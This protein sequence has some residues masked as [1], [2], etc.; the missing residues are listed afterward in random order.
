MARAYLQRQGQEREPEPV[1]ARPDGPHRYRYPQKQ[2]HQY[3]HHPVPPPTT[4]TAPSTS[5]LPG[6]SSTKEGGGRSGG[7]SRWSSNERG[8]GG[9]GRSG[10]ETPGDLLEG[11]VV[12]DLQKGG[13]GSL[14]GD[15]GL[16]VVVGA[17]EA[18]QDIEHQDPIG[19]RT[20]EVV[21]SIGHALHPPAELTNREV[22][23]LEGAEGGVELEGAKL[24][25]AEEL[26]LEC[27]PGLPRSAA[28]CPDEVLKI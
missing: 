2:D 3:H 5:G 18:P 26:P 7:G 21:K 4:S 6:G 8:G 10:R 1:S 15:P 24:G 20:P 13:E 12:P 28:V 16:Q 14:A 23:L 25:V 9:R 17:S 27:H 19:H 11:E 22:P